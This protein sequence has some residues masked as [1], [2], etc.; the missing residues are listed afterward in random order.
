MQEAERTLYLNW[1]APSDR[2]L[3]L[4][5]PSKLVQRLGLDRLPAG[6]RYL[7]LDE[8]HKHSQWKDLLK[9]LFDLHEREL[10]IL[11]TGSARLDLYPSA[12]DSLV[13]RYF[14]RRMHPLS[15]AECLRSTTATSLVQEPIQGDAD[16]LPALLRFGGFPEPFLKQDTR[17]WNN[18]SRTRRMQLLREDLRDLTQVRDLSQ[19]EV[20]ANLLRAQVGASCNY[21]GMARDLRASVD[22]VR[23]WCDVLEKLFTVFTVRPWHRNVRR[24]LRKE[25]KYYLWDWSQ[26]QDEGARAENLV[27][28]AL[29]KFCHYWTDSGEGDFALHYLRD[30]EGREVDFLV[31]RDGE[32]WF[33]VEV[34]LSGK[35]ALSP[36]LEYFSKQIGSVKAFQA[37]FDLDYLE[38]DCLALDRPR[39][40]PA[41][42]FLSQLI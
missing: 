38:A 12:G 6:E 26:V 31:S 37:A 27:A 15:L 22:S 7:A 14:A 36:H 34:K 16:L 41:R 18:W 8:L 32:A 28:S 9:G 33:M 13:G 24:A 25:P 39:I 11:V 29:L 10:K 19:V 21:S 5:D 3:L 17:F 40:V 35:A 42:T 23:R 30:K 4:A 20:L 1:D 2:E